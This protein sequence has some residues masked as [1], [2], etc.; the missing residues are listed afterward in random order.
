MDVAAYAAVGA[1]DDVFLGDN[2]S[3]R[4][5]A[6]GYQ[7]CVLGEVEWLT[8]L[9]MRIFPGG[10]PRKPTTACR[11]EGDLSLIAQLLE[12]LTTWLL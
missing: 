4:D 9:G 2:F 10:V 3:E 8:T 12:T 11:Y 1:G 7:F 6:I 5:D